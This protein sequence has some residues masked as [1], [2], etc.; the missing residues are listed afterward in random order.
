[1]RAVSYIGRSAADTFILLSGV[2]GITFS[3]ISAYSFPADDGAVLLSCILFCLL[4]SFIFNLRGRIFSAAAVLLSLGAAAV[5]YE[6]II[7]AFKG[8]L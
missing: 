5:F 2:A 3:L 4:Y 7:N 1:M 8:F 6:R